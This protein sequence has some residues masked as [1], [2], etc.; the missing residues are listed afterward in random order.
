[1]HFTKLGTAGRTVEQDKPVLELGKSFFRAALSHNSV[2]SWHTFFQGSALKRFSKNTQE[3][4]AFNQE[5][6]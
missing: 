1:M 3:T 5:K 6:I 2:S 4:E